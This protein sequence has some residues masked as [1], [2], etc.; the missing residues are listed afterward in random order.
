MA[1]KVLEKR[2]REVLILAVEML[3][4][5]D[6]LL[7]LM[8]Q[9]VDLF[10]ADDDKLQ[11]VLKWIKQ[12]HNYLNISYHPIE[13]LEILYIDFVPE[14][15]I[16]NPLKG[17]GLSWTVIFS[18]LEGDLTIHISLSYIDKLT[19]FPSQDYHQLASLLLEALN[20]T[21]NMVLDREDIRDS[22]IEFKSQLP[23]PEMEE[24][25]FIKLWKNNG[26][27]WHKQLRE[28]A[29]KYR[30]IGHDWQFSEEEKTKLKK[31]SDANKL[32]WEWIETTKSDRCY[33]T[34][35]VRAELKNTLLWPI[36]DIEKYEQKK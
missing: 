18:D 35:E 29:I 3:D 13:I 10:I 1:S 33:L 8:K 24:Q 6:C 22:L 16:E 2:W 14:L 20:Q 4:I 30:D 27:K 36:E 28:I 21:I 23:D 15:K 25:S 12:R 31:Y 7:Q 9:Q 26:K 11:Q 19:F 34:R 32:L 17:L 5:A